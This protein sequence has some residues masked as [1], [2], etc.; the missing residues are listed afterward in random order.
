MEGSDREALLQ[1]VSEQNSR[2]QQLI[3]AIVK[4]IM[5]SRDVLRHQRPEDSHSADG[6]GAN[7]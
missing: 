3:E 4:L 6:G 5:R 1:K 2:L 7:S